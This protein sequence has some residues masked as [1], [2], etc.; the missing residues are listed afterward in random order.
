[1]K[2]FKFFFVAEMFKLFPQSIVRVFFMHIKKILK[3]IN[4]KHVKQ[5]ARKYKNKINSK[6]LTIKNQNAKFLEPFFILIWT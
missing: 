2:L 5:R 3:R 6:K 1:M 4:R